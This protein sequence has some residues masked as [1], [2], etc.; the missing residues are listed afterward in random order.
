MTESGR[1]RARRPLES[2]DVQA[3]HRRRVPA[4]RVGPHLRGAGGAGGFLANAALA[5]RKDARDA[6]VAA[7]KAAAGVGR[8][9]RVQPRAGPVPGRGDAR[10]PARP[11]RRGGRRRR[12]CGTADERRGPTV[13]ARDRP[14]GLVR[15]LERQ[16]RAGRRR[17]EP[18]GGPY[19][20]LSV[21]EPTG[22]VAVL[23]PQASS[24]LG[25]VSVVAPVIVSGNTVVVLA[26]QERPLPAIT[27]ARCSR[28]PTC[29]AASSTCSPA[30]P[31]RWRRGWPRTRRVR[32]IDLA[33]AA[34]LPGRR[35]RWTGARWSG[36]RGDTDPRRPA[37]RL[38]AVVRAGG[39]A[40]LDGATTGP[41]RILAFTETKTVWHPKGR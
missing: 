41:A 12:G 2:E 7:R 23:A 27:L 4:Q 20:N 29:P 24:L 39:R 13:D 18:G 35:R 10:G 26:S 1:R 17:R 16:D 6:V 22:V 14:L 37:R 30:R 15:R 3:L 25:L 40:G 32:A 19:F 5:S 31:P 8:R 9:D 36:G 33:G 11:V 38:G 21:P 28:R 34:P